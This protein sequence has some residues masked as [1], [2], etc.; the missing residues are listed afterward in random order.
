MP[1]FDARGLLETHTV[2]VWDVL[3]PGHLGHDGE[4]EIAETTHLVFPY[5][6]IYVHH[7]GRARTVAE[8]NH[9]L[10]INADEPY[11]VSH[12][13]EG[14]DA[15]L[16]IGV[17]A[18]TLM[19]LAPADYLAGPDRPAFNRSRLPIDGHAQAQAAVLQ[20]RLRDGLV[21]DLEGETLT[22]SL[23][24]RTLGG[25]HPARA[26]NGTRRQRLVDRAKLVVSS[27]LNRRWSLA[28]VGERVGASPVYLTD[29]FQQVEGI[30]LYRYQ[31]RLRLAKALH[32]LRDCDSVTDLAFDLG[33]SSHSHF[34]AAF[35]QAFG[36]TPS[37]L[38]RS[39][40]SA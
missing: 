18:A 23:L 22:L 9:V 40:M 8:A 10:F 4:E 26:V 37:T 39:L 31:L 35:R 30:P 25:R 12:P 17:D 34:S 11:R 21:D 3:C 7:V 33:F 5:R 15:T 27:D 20:H 29:V 6:G 13:V 38:R 2:A 28:D 32:M 24:R 36:Q 14:G 19:E 1:E 16:S